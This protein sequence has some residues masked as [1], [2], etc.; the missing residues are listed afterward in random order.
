MNKHETYI[1]PFTDFGFK[2][3]FGEDNSKKSLISFLNDVLP[4]R[5]K[6]TRI[7]FGNSENLGLHI[8]SRKAVFDISC[9]DSKGNH[10]I[11]E[12]QN[13]EQ[14][15]F[16]DRTVFYSTFPIQKQA[17]KGST[18]DYNLDPVYCVGLLGFM[19]NEDF[20]P[21]KKEEVI[22]QNEYLHVVKLKD[23]KNKIFYDKLTYIYIE[24]P[25]FN[26]KESEL[27]TH[28]DKWL[29][30]LK[31]LPLLDSI[32]KIL[33]EPVF[34]GAF[35]T[36]SIANLSPD[37]QIK[38]TRSFLAYSDSVNIVD[39]ALEKGEKIG[40]AKGEKIGI[41][42]G[43]KI[44]IEKGEKIGIEKGI[45]KVAVNLLK[46]G[47]KPGEVSKVTGMTLDQIKKLK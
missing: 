21:S 18:W 36:A 1:N 25:K 13:A 33:N 42:K 20:T 7:T 24:F 14:K 2:K 12:L 10:F 6:I 16:K 38:Y 34:A 19:F 43:E 47:L 17:K 40:I 15:Y 45:K 22:E 9:I 32:P 41:A 37:E 46:A 26:K 5:Y 28:L 8:D 35:E 23:Q 11:V 3:L 44:G 27:T 29:Y 31:H 4:I 30:F 39:T